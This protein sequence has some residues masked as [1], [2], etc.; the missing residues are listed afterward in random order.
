MVRPQI[1]RDVR[2]PLRRGRRWRAAGGHHL[3]LVALLDEVLEDHA[4]AG[5][6]A[7]ALAHHAVQDPHARP[8]IARASLRPGP[9]PPVVGRGLGPRAALLHRAPAAAAVAARVQVHVGAVRGGALAHPA[10]LVAHQLQRVEHGV[11]QQAARGAGRGVEAR[12]ERVGLH[13][14]AAR[15]PPEPALGQDHHRRP[16]ARE[17]GRPETVAQHPR[18]LQLTAG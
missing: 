10:G 8:R 5:G 1:S 11:D 4:R 9:V 17:Q 3:D 6:V 18:R 12:L 2:H 13:P 16:V 7:H 14:Q 15:R